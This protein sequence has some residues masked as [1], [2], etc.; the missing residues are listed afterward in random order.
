MSFRDC[1]ARIIACDPRYSIDAYAFVLESLNYARHRKLKAAGRSA[2]KPGAQAKGAGSPTS[3]TRRPRES[4]HVTG[5]ELCVALRDLA[6]DQFG[7]LAATFLGQWGVYS[8]SDIGEIVYNM[9]ATGDLEKTPND[10]RSDFD[11]V[12]DFDSALRPKTLLAAEDH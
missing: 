5:P 11:D 7:F 1:L 12:F 6:L 4:E 10:S 3:R 9:I 8:T 2:D